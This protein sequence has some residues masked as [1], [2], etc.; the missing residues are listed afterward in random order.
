M[1]ASHCLT[2]AATNSI[3]AV[4]PKVLQPRGIYISD[5]HI[6]SIKVKT[7]DVE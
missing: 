2:G 7:R 5:L 3:T 6:A 1:T 4:P